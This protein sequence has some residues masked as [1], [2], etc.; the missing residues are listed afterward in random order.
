MTEPSDDAAVLVV[1]DDPL[2]RRTVAAVLE[3]LGCRVTE[4]ADAAEAVAAASRTRFALVVL[5]VQ[6][7]GLDGPATL[8]ALRW[9]APGLRCC[10]LS[11]NPGGH[12]RE[13]LLGAGGGDWFLPKPVTKQE[14]AAVLAA[15][16]CVP[17]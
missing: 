8:T 10:Y 7:P 15:A 5:D 16:G 1:D 13:A 4:A 2:V 12:T 14:L 11:G 6:M 17:P 3:R 9:Y